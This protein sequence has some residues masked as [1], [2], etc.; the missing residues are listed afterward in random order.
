M[1]RTMLCLV[2]FGA[3]A[4][5]APNQAPTAPSESTLKSTIDRILAE[6][7]A[8]KQ[9]EADL[10]AHLEQDKI[11]EAAFTTTINRAEKNAQAIRELIDQLDALYDQLSDHQKDTVR[12]AWTVAELFSAFVDNQKEG[13]GKLADKD[14]RQEILA[15]AQCSVRRAAMLEETLNRLT[16]R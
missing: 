8:A 5:A 11:D 14:S 6:S 15:N 1:K 7:R 9:A 10:A 16:Q 13:I 3:L 4:C 12:E 2:V